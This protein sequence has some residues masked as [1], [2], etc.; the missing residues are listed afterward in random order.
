[1]PIDRARQAVFARSHGRS[2]FFLHMA[3]KLL[4]YSKARES[5]RTG[6]K[7]SIAHTQMT[8]N[9]ANAACCDRRIKHA[10][11]ETLGTKHEESKPHGLHCFAL[12]HVAFFAE[13]QSYNTRRSLLLPPKMPREN[14]ERQPVW[15]GCFCPMLQLLPCSLSLSFC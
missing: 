15:V 9:G 8:K 14:D 10:H 5:K 6:R 13:G 2:L 1:M 7:M 12:L 11:S 4:Q 3:H